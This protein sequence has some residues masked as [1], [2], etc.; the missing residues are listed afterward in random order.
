MSSFLNSVL[1]TNI[2]KAVQVLIAPRNTD[3]NFNRAEES[4]QSHEQIL[5]NQNLFGQDE[6]QQLFFP[7]GRPRVPK[8]LESTRN[9]DRVK[10][11]QSLLTQGE[12]NNSSNL[13]FNLV[14][15]LIFQNLIETSHQ[16]TQVEYYSKEEFQQ[17]SLEERKRRQRLL[18]ISE[19]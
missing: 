12:T 16:T 18:E 5:E 3:E 19:N 1:Y 17:L 7:D 10:Y 11:I 14:L 9:N 15:P 13:P 6:K 8:S 4:F 2:A